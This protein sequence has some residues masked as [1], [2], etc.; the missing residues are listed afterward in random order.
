MPG[1]KKFDN[2][3]QVKSGVDVAQFTAERGARIRDGHKGTKVEFPGR[4]SF[5]VNL[6]KELSKSDKAHYKRLLKIFGIISIILFFVFTEIIL[7]LFGYQVV[8]F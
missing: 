7:P 2:F 3:D 8:W 5:L 4:G 1:K 6:S